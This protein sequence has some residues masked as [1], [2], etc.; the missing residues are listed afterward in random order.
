M[1]IWQ[2]VRP[3]Y[4]YILLASVSLFLSVA[5]LPMAGAAARQSPLP[6]T[7]TAQEVQTYEAFRL[8]MTSQPADVQN[9]DDDVV[10]ARYAAQLRAEGQ[11]ERDAAATIASL[12]AIGDRA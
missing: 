10:F 3:A 7:A 1:S 2:S 4:T 5:L 12:K 9:A 11:S 8:W 6:P